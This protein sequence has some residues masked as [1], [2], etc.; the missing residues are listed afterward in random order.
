MQAYNLMMTA[1]RALKRWSTST[2]IH[3]AISQ[4][5]VIIVV[6]GQVGKH[7]RGSYYLNRL[8]TWFSN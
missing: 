4:T 1:V 2:S 7:Q 5:T 8:Q 6:I 3:G